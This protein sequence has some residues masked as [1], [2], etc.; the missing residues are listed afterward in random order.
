MRMVFCVDIL[1]EKIC[2]TIA[3]T[4]V[5]HF[6]TS[7]TVKANINKLLSLIYE[8]CK[9]CELLFWFR[10][11]TK[12]SV[13][14]QLTATRHSV[15]ANTPTKGHSL[16]NFHKPPPEKLQCLEIAIVELDQQNP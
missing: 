12:C 2:S 4:N 9:T 11:F 16:R 8:S 6:V 1:R 10:K 14:Y 3:F 15:E 5:W 13:E 7:D